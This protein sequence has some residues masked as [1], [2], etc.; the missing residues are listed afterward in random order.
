[1]TILLINPVPRQ[2]S[3]IKR[4]AVAKIHYP[5]ELGEKRSKTPTT[6]IS[7]TS[8]ERSELDSI[9]G[10]PAKIGKLMKQK[11]IAEDRK[12]LMKQAE[13]ISEEFLTEENMDSPKF[14]IPPEKFDSTPRSRSQS[15]ELPDFIG[16]YFLKLSTKS[17]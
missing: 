9:I 16:T 13:N 14:L 3:I 7:H 15:V 8:S 12:C 17:L 4:G 10:T 1:M 6:V 11:D 2:A 5:I